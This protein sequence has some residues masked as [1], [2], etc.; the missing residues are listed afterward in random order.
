[1]RGGYDFTLENTVPENSGV[2]NVLNAF[3]NC[4]SKN[5]DEIKGIIV[6]TKTTAPKSYVRV[7]PLAL[8]RVVCIKS[9]IPLGVTHGRLRL[10]W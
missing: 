8:K 7:V 6:I 4:L 9:G 5:I 2:Y 3:Y 1:M 10:F